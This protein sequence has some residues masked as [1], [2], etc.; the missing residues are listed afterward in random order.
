M[1]KLA[2]LSLFIGLSALPALAA[3]ET[4]KDAS[5][6]DVNCST[7][8]AADPDS[9]TKACALKCEKSGFG[10]YTSDK[11]LLKFDADGNKKVAEALQA[12]DK[13]DHLRADVT[14]DVSGDTIKVSS[15]KL[16]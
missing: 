3:T 6:I 16:Q 4:F 5:V 12:T 13:K 7:K 2:A 1:K 9:H 14:G 8:A 10:I 15:F 11:K